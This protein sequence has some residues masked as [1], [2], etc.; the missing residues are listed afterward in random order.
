MYESDQVGSDQ[1]RRD[2][3]KKGDQCSALLEKPFDEFID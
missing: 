3:K 1:G 2:Q